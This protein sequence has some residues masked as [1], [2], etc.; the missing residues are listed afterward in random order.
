MSADPLSGLG[1]G[2][3]VLA[4]PMA[5]GP[6][7]PELVVAAAAAGSLGL[8][9][10]GYR[11]AESLAAQM[12][13]VSERTDTFG[14]NLFAPNPVPVDRDAYLRYREL[15]LPAAEEYA[16]ELPGEPVEDDD[17]WRDKIDLLLERPPALVSFT[18]GIPEPSVLA[19]LRGA[20]SLLVQKVTSRSEAL[21]AAAAGVDALVVQ[22]A[23]AGG[24]SGTL[25]PGRSPERTGLKDLIV[26]ITGLIGLPCI[27]AGG[28]ATP[29]AAASMIDT[30]ARA[31]M[32]GTALLL[33]PESGTSAA[34]RSALLGRDRPTVV[35]HAFTGRPARG[36]RN[37]FIDAY[38]AQAPL[39]YPALHH[40]T[41]PLRRAAA[42]AGDPEPVNLWAGTGYRAARERP[43]AETLQHLASRL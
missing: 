18:F 39:G 6:T 23:D 42:A 36:L 31:V 27:A 30:G 7:T 3:L 26:E 33:A 32:V 13:A 16:V 2:C 35:T 9:D 8:L 41:R 40:L 24:H 38:D 25:T 37:R 22:S 28:I 17:H 34:H 43:A 15:L 20:G 29:E 4:A 14:V 12:A 10:G 19:Q 1:I 5:G 21:R 11:T